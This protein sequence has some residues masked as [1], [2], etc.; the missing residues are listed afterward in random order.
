[1]INKDTPSGFEWHT[2]DPRYRTQLLLPRLLTERLCVPTDVED[3]E[4]DSAKVAVNQTIKILLERG[5]LN[6]Q[7]IQ[8][9]LLRYA[10]QPAP[11]PVSLI[12]PKPADVK[13]VQV[14]N[15]A[16]INQLR[17]ESG[18]NRSLKAVM[19][20]F[21]A[22]DNGQRV[23]KKIPPRFLHNINRL[24]RYYPNCV[25]FL[26]FVAAFALLGLKRP[27]PVFYFPPVILVGPPGIGKTA[28]VNALADLVGVST[29]Q[30]DL[31]STTAGMVIGGMSTQWADAKTGVVIDLLREGEAA[32]P[33]VLL[34]ELDKASSDAKFAPLGPLYNLLEQGTARKFIDEALDFPSDAS[35]VL[36]VATANTLDTIPKPILSRFTV[37]EVKAIGAQQHRAVTQSIYCS[38]L[39]LHDCADLFQ[40]KLDNLVIE[41]LHDKSPREIKATLRRALANAA[42]RN[43]KAKKLAVQGQDLMMDQAMK[44]V[45]GQYDGRQ[46]FGFTQP[47]QHSLTVH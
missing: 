32:N 43:P 46:G 5:N 40:A 36:Y 21:K 22:D 41:A 14:F 1:M 31:A 23:L 42:R 27:Y 9:Q 26:D 12:K 45:F 19:S 3:D 28:V 11:A 2:L 34:D 24:K 47:G 4:D 35:N 6:L 16:L 25:E 18:N 29:R 10:R 7:Q 44:A 13:Q 33:I 37:V 15:M 38:L 30:V 20:R 39:E 17:T 8:D